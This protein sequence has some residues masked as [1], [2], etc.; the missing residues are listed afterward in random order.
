MKRAT[1]SRMPSQEPTHERIARIAE[2]IHER[3]SIK[4]LP[5]MRE[6]ELISFERQHGITLP[7][8]YRDFLLNIGG[9]ASG[10]PLYGLEGLVRIAPYRTLEER[11][12][13]PNLP[14]IRDPFPFT[15]LW[16]WED[17]DTSEEGTK[18]QIFHGILTLGTEGC[19]QDWALVI[20][21]PERGNM[22]MIADVGITP[23]DPKRD[24]LQWFEDW[25]DG[26]DNW[27]KQKGQ[28]V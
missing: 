3:G 24:F 10:P 23:T 5:T 18:D 1:G 27:W 4:L 6:E 19:G 28:A 16:I 25:L 17:G 8:G 21:G 2:K 7:T 13:D 22:W 11:S 14:C 20:T 15:K 26:V 9:G 12:Y